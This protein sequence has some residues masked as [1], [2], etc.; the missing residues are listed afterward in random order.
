MT[1]QFQPEDNLNVEITRTDKFGIWILL[2]GRTYFVEY[3]KAAWLQDPT[4]REMLNIKLLNGF[5]F[6]TLSLD[7]DLNFD[8]L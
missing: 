7:I 1:T 3:E 6:R 4:V 5:H 2:N 8:A